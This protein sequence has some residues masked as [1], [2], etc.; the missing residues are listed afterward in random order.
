ML[1]SLSDGAQSYLRAMVEVMG[2]DHVAPTGK[3]SERLGKTH[4]QLATTRQL[5]IDEGVIVACGRGSVR[6]A[7][8]YLRAYL[9]KSTR[10]P[11]PLSLLDQWDV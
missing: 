5:L 11:D 6:F 10:E 7:I 9:S 4:Q 3:V 8:P 1:R 2:D